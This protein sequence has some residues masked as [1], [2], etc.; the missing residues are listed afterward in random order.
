MPEGDPFKN[1]LLGRKEPAEVLTHLVGSIEGPC[2]IAV[3]AA[4]GTGKTTFLR[5][6]ARH[7]CNEGFSVVEFNAWETDFSG[8]PF[9][10]LSTEL[11]ENLRDSTNPTL[12]DVV[13]RTKE[14]AK[15][16][17]RTSLPGVVRLA[18]SG[19][20]D[21][22]SLLE[23]QDRMSEYREAR[24]AL[25]NFRESLQEM[26]NALAAS[27]EHRPLVVVIDELDRCRPS[28]AVELL[29]AA[30]HLFAVDG[31]VFVL[32]LNRSELAHSI[33]TLYGI[34]FDAI[35]YLRRF[36][37]VDFRLPDPDRAAFI[38]QAL[39]AVRI[40]EYFERSK[41]R[42]AK[43]DQ[44]GELVGDW[45]KRFFDSPDLNLRRV[46]KAIHHL[47][48]VFASLRSNQRSF[49][50]TAVAALI[51]RTVDSELYYKFVRGEATDLEVVDRV[52]SRSNGLRKLQQEHAGCV[53]ES[54][55]VLAAH[56]VSGDE[57]ESID[58]PLVQ[59]YQKQFQE[60]TPAPTSKKHAEQVLKRFEILKD[61]RAV[62]K[63][64]GP[65]RRFGFKHSVD[66]L[67][68]ISPGLIGKRTG[69][70]SP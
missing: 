55:I 19:F 36:I 62:L 35:G 8:D 12:E 14:M 44:E 10:A 40:S 6:W 58:S 42:N 25:S 5:L 22:Q 41:D 24:K 51:L 30:K 56:E 59:R 67:E 37:D 18:T 32:A 47:G 49:A 50:N 65:S 69:A 7:L 15:E 70:A 3:D 54:L 57:S 16:V 63:F 21:L 17:F 28:Y 60:G 61:G 43:D 27:N 64:G 39:D 13:G 23:K 4:W 66:R 31:V 53:F 26:A 48:L 2:V 11:T 52:F 33:R 1:D 9:M 34:G 46:A 38:D 45:L 68:L 29:E 20:V